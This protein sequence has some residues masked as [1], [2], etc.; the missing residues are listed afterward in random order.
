MNVFLPVRYPLGG[1]SGHVTSFTC[2]STK[3][4]K[5]GFSKHILWKSFTAVFPSLGIIFSKKLTPTIRRVR[6]NEMD[7]IESQ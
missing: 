1:P 7:S 6:K 5:S 2:D 3:A 4:L